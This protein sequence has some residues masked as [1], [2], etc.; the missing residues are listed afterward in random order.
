MMP[1]R[2]AIV[3]TGWLL[4]MLGGAMALIIG[5]GDFIVITAGIFTSFG[6]LYVL[7]LVDPAARQFMGNGWPTRLCRSSAGA[8][9][10]LMA[11]SGLSSSMDG[12]RKA[13]IY[14]NSTGLSLI[15]VGLLPLCWGIY[16]LNLAITG[17]QFQHR[18]RT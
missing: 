4:V 13:T 15:L 6:G 3:A 1:G 9:G 10:L 18:S 12:I 5:K 8:V 11:F 17:F 16:I 2:I 7:S 14:H